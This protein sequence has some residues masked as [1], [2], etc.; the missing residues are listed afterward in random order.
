MWENA[1]QASLYKVPFLPVQ[2][3]HLSYHGQR[4]A[5][6]FCFF[7][8]IK[9][10]KTVTIT[11]SFQLLLHM[12]PWGSHEPH[13]GMVPQSF[14]LPNRLRVRFFSFGYPALS[15]QLLILPSF[16]IRCECLA[17][18]NCVNTSNK[19][20]NHT[21]WGEMMASHPYPHARVITP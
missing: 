14:I 10:L 19:L 18:A 7:R 2:L 9:C 15:S 1:R 20:P 13:A 16:K 6:L 21:S 11:R 3:R 12:W 4:Y 17:Q 8:N 5:N